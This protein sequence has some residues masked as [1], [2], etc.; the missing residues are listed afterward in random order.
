MGRHHFVGAVLGAGAGAAAIFFLDP[1]SGTRRRALV[2]DQIHHYAGALP[3]RLGRAGR[4]ATGP[5]LGLAHRLARLTHGGAREAPVDDTEL[6]HR[7]E[8]ELGRD[9]S[10]P[11]GDLNFDV[12]DSV[13]RIRGAV[14]YARTAAW[15][16]EEAAK[17]D[18]VGAVLSL[19]RTPDGIPVGGTAGNLDLIDA[20]PR[21]EIRS[22][23]VREALLERWPS[24]TDADILASNGHVGTLVA[25][26]STYTGIS[27]EAIRVELEEI[28]LSVV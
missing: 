13:V 20:G 27:N 5:C 25:A 6:K 2:R 22:E 23:A 15:I 12:V 26:I 9:P 24:L 10:M 21:A 11:L 3:Y 7:V 16:V 28:L 19:M 14:P 4:A 17:V 1:R 18:G 8:S